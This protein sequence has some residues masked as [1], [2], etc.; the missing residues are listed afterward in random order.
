MIINLRRRAFTLLE[1]LVVV[2]ILAVLIFT[3]SIYIPLFITRAYD[4]R[5]KV[6]LHRMKVNLELYYDFANQYPENIPDCGQP[7]M[8]KTQKILNSI[9]CDPTTK[10]PYYYQIRKEDTLSFRIYTLLVNTKDLSISDVGCLGGCG[11]DCSYNYGVSSANVNL[12]RCSYVCAPGGGK[13]G[14]C[15][16]FQDTELSICPK[17]YY[18]D[19]T[20]K[21][22]CNNPK[23]RCQNASGKNK[24]Y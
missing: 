14:S 13:P 9:P 18:Q 3:S 20:C 7:L 23:N 22:E 8:Y 6:D 15:E 11:P 2:A 21:N 16:I 10:K 24:P 5:R 17:V 1:L 19:S 12:I 4:A